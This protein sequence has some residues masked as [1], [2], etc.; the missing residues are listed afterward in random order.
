MKQ[1]FM[2]KLKA[3]IKEFILVSISFLGMLICLQIILPAYATPNLSTEIKLTASETPILD[4]AKKQDKTHIVATTMQTIVNA[5]EPAIWNALIDF[6]KYPTIFKGIDSVEITKR[7]GE[8]VYT[9]SHLKPALFVKQT[10]QHTVNDLSAGPTTLNWQMID[11][12]FKYLKGKWE[13]QKKTINTC[14]VKYTLYVDLGPLV[15][16]SLIN[17]VVHRMQQQIVADLKQ[18]VETE[19]SNEQSHK[20]SSAHN[21]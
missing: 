1:E 2:A 3:N 20:L 4:A 19:Y 5:D 10:L 6:K 9:E 8:L 14:S 17:L 18:Y 21:F 15:P 16:A 11:G 12:N 13:L 7:D